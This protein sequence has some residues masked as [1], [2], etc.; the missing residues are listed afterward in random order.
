MVSLTG[1][2]PV[3]STVVPLLHHH[4]TATTH[5]RTLIAVVATGMILTAFACKTT[6]R[7]TQVEIDRKN[8]P[9]FTFSGDGQVS[10]IVVTDVSANDLSGFDPKRIMWEIVPTRENKPSRFP[11]VTYGVVP[12]GFVQRTPSAGAPRSLEEEKPYRV[13]AP[14]N[15]ADSRKLIFLIRNGQA[16]LVTM[17]DDMEWYVQTPTPN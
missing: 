16:L 7:A 6:P 15:G 3:N 17:A 1:G 11:K 8:P 9:T 10:A 4:M 5:T 12:A 2:N 14:T 13:T